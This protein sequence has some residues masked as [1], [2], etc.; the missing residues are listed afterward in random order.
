MDYLATLCI[1]QL[2]D[3]AGFTALMKIAEPRYV[4]SLSAQYFKTVIT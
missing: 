3:G 4:L 1:Q 2:F